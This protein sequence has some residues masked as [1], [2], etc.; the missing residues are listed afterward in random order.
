MDKA[1][2]QKKYWLIPVLLIVAGLC[3]LLAIRIVNWIDW[4]NNDF[5]TFW[6]AGHLIT[7]GGD[8]YSPAQWVAG[9]HEFG[10]TWI[11]NQAYV[12][13]LPLSLIFAPLGLLP[14]KAAY[15]VWVAISIGMILA[16]LV[17]LLAHRKGPDFLRVF[18]P[19]L[20]GTIFFRPAVLTLV[21]GQ[22]S[23]WLLLILI[24]TVYLW[25]R[26]KW[27]W[28]SLLLPLLMLKPN[29][30]APMLALVGLWLLLNKKYKSI[31]VIGA[32]L[33]GLLLIGLVQN[34]QWVSEYWGIGN[35]KVAETFGGSPTVWGL[36]YLVCNHGPTC[37]LASGGVAAALV[38]IVFIWLIASRRYRLSPLTIIS[39]ATT[40]TLLVTPYT[41]TYDQ[42]LLIL[43]I[44]NITLA[45]DASGVR[46]WLIAGLFLAIDVLL[47]MALIVDTLL[48]VEIL[49][50]LL[51]LLLFIFY[52]CLR[53]RTIP[54]IYQP[55]LNED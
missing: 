39:L 32:G 2:R 50:A 28:G 41:W 36:G 53:S 4:R 31:A 11:P 7:L 8:P 45:M 38:C 54:K 23:A 40:V 22:I 15:I 19:L 17:L 55:L 12:Y 44:V 13:P 48:R 35:V 20:V 43:P 6:L 5:F 30:G 25:E 21:N 10:V 34:P 9:H 37:T 47:V 52:A 33:V 1:A 46:Y 14:L 16:S 24:G 27:E 3:V 51:P 42:I 26:G 18:L 49:N 29:I